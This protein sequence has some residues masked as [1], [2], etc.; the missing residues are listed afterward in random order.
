MK[1][2]M[3]LCASRHPMPEVANRA[4][5]PEAVN[6]VEV[7]TLRKMAENAIPADCTE[8][9]VYVT[10]LTAAMLAV[11]DVCEARAIDLTAMHYDRETGN[12]YPQQVMWFVTCPWCGTRHA[13]RGN[14][15]PVCGGN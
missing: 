6:P 15:C 3:A 14:Y 5:F 11:V 10:G 4:I 2:T 7:D 8:L 9:T 13:A 1:Y 12:Y